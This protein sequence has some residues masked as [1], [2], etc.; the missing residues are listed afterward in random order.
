M[1]APLAVV[2]A[3]AASRAAPA[4]HWCF[5]INNPEGELSLSDALMEKL[6]Y[7]VWQLEQGA[8]GTRHLQGYLQLKEKARL[9]ALKRYWPTAHLEVARGTPA[10]NKIYCT[11]PET[12]VEGPWERGTLVGG[13]GTRTDL[14]DLG[15][16]INAG[17]K[18]R[19][20]AR[21]T[22]E[23][24]IRYARGIQTLESVV[25]RVA[26][27]GEVR[28]PYVYVLWGAP[29]TGKTLLPHSL[30]SEADLFTYHL[31]PGG[32]QWFDGYDGQ[33]V[34]IIDDFTGWVPFR[35]LLMWL[36]RYPLRLEVKGGFTYARW[37]RVFITSNRPP[38]EWYHDADYAALER[39]ISYVWH[40]PDDLELARSVTQGTLYTH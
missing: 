16:S 37:H 25:S 7:I 4:K 36:D 13:K 17:K 40:F 11:K 20:V 27:E 24:V 10:Q 33:P 30:Y 39:R 32:H 38:E 1:A 12:R 14:H 19:E 8:E 31:I 3:P 28:D 34:L 22:P 5:T 6:Q 23:L 2:A 35:T 9:T 26:A 15:A 18:L 21:D 29:G